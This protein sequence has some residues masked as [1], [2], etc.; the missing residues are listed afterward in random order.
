L[1]L[2]SIV[3][4]TLSLL[5]YLIDRE[6]S[7]KTDKVGFSMIRSFL[8]ILGLINNKNNR[9]KTNDLILNRKIE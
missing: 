4:T 5:K 8:G 6:L 1:K 3:L 2:E 7:I 9:K